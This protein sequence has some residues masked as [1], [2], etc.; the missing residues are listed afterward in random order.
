M[1]YTI[2]K[3][4]GQ[5]L[6]VLEDGTLDTTTSLGLVGRNYVGY[7]E[8]QNE[9]FV[10]LLENFANPNPPP[11]PIEGQI[12]YDTD[13]N[14]LSVYTGTEWSVIGNATLADSP[15]E[16]TSVGSLWLRT[17]INTLHVWN[18]TEWKFIGPEAVPGFGTTRARSGTLLDSLGT[19]R[20]VIFFT[21]ND[22]V[23]AV[24]SSVDFEIS[25]SEPLPGFDDIS[26]GIT[27]SA[28]SLVRGNLRGL[29]DRSNRL[30]TPRNINGVAFDG[31]SDIT[32]KSSTTR[33]LNVGDYL[34]GANFDGS[35]TTTWSVDATSANVIGKVVVRNSEGGFAAGTITANLVGNVTGNVTAASGVS[36]FDEVRANRFIGATLTGNAFSATKL[37]TA[38]NINGVP[39]DGTADVTV[40]ANAETLT[41]T[42]IKNTVTQS[43]LTTVGTL[44]EVNVAGPARIGPGQNLILN[45]DSSSPF[46]NTSYNN[47]KI[48]AGSGANE[49]GLI[50][51]NK[52]RSLSEGGSGN[53]SI[54]PLN[55]ASHD[56]GH[57]NRKWN[58]VHAQEFKGNADTAT[59]ATTSINLQGGANG[60]LP[61]QISTGVT[62]Y[63]P[64]GIN[65][66]ILRV[67]GGVPSWQNFSFENINSG[68]F[69]VFKNNSNVTVPNYTSAAPVTINVDATSTNTASKVVA[70]DASGNFS[71][72]TITANLTGN[73]TGN[74]SGNA[75]TATKLQTAR[76]INGVSF[77]GTA[78]ITVSAN[79]PTKVAKAGDTMSGFL[80][81]H[82]EPT[83]TRHAA[84]KKY[85]DDVFAATGNVKAWVVFEGSNGSI[86][87]SL[88]VNSVSRIGTGY[89]RITLASG[90]FANGNFSAA[91]MASDTD[92][93]VTY[94][95][96]NANELYVYT[97]DNGSGNNTAQTTGGRVMVM[98]AG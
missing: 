9:N 55:S 4:N 65:G 98:M 62:S 53:S 28:N 76:T 70:R 71:A 17:P 60:A 38:R 15:P 92:H 42:F 50:I 45:A 26:I 67:A 82:A 87:S 10:F 1:P 89:Y 20:P 81:L 18:G 22:V 23:I 97:I 21:V 27:L 3:Y 74:V 11:R 36:T 44:V 39:F 31:S 46:I 40:T 78:N 86:I 56:L 37:Q 69:V 57:V 90:T 30:E 34:V 43:N 64:I 80:T 5:E 33:Q 59:L 19:R 68:D 12:W 24:A 14:A 13:T 75:G 73:V 83:A 84:T 66:Q 96:S 72:G 32:I 95:G 29:A 91:G 58:R 25:P 61:Y 6:V 7:G 47:L 52:T 49:D 93:F 79:D 54:V 51:W 48:S 2:N 77:D 94:N 8:T 35:N 85:V 88:R 16:T 63:L 41:G